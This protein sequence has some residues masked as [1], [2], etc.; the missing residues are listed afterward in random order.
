MIHL[1]NNIHFTS[2]RSFPILDRAFRRNILHRRTF[3]EDVLAS[4]TV[5]QTP[6]P[7]KAVITTA[8]LACCRRQFEAENRA[9]RLGPRNKRAPSLEKLAQTALSPAALIRGISL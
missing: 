1:N 6:V 9:D 7:L 5:A 3:T 2:F 4:N 8:E